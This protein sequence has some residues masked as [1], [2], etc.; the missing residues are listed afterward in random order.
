MSAA[1]WLQFGVLIGVLLVTAP[2]LGWYMAKVYGEEDKAP[3]DRVFGPVERLIY[4]I[5]RVNPEREQRWTVYAFS[6]FA[7]SLVSFLLLYGLQRLQGQLP[8]NPV[9]LPAVVPNVAFNA[10]VSFMTNTNWQNY[11][12]EA[13]MSHLTQMA[14][15]TVQNFVSAA[16]GMAVMAALIRG[17]A[18]RR[19]STLGNF[20]VDLTRGT[21]RILFPL[22]FVV[23]LLLV[24]QGVIQ[25]FAGHTKV[26]AVEGT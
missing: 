10:A 13:T 26:S 18:R 1:G 12:G 23:A 15:L 20:W 24:S 4:R 11:A 7:F 19:A 14:G 5:C 25:N 9:D 17:L 8:L 21:I 16:A 3:G 6:L 2:P 22:S